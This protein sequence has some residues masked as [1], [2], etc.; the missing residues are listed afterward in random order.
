[1][2]L[3]L[4]LVLCFT[5]FSVSA[6]WTSLITGT[7]NELRS[8]DAVDA[9]LVYAAGANV[10]IKSING[11][12]NWSTLPLLN[13]SNQPINSLVINDL[14]FFDAQT[15]IAVGAQASFTRVILRTIDGG[16]HW[17]TIVTANDLNSWTGGY[18]KVHFVSNTHG[19]AVGS[20]GV[21]SRTVNGGLNW[22]TVTIPNVTNLYDVQF[23]DNQIGMVCGE[24]DYSGNG[25]QQILAQSTNGG[26]TWSQ[27]IQSSG[28]TL[29]E[30][31]LL[32]PLTVFLSNDQGFVIRLNDGVNLQNST[33][34]S[35]VDAAVVHRFHF[36]SNTSG[37]A[38]CDYSIRKTNNT[39]LFWE[40]A[41]LPLSSGQQLRDFDFLADGVTGFAVGKA[42]KA[43][44]TTNGGEPLLPMAYFYPESY[45]Y[46]QLCADSVY[47]FVNSAPEAEY[48]SQ[49]YVDGLLY[50]TENDIDISFPATATTYSVRLRITGPNG[51]S[52]YTQTFETAPELDFVYGTLEWVYG[53][54]VCA[55]GYLNFQVKNPAPNI[56]YTAF[57]NDVPFQALYVNNSDPLLF[58]T[59][60]MTE[61]AVI[62]VEATNYGPCGSLVQADT[63]QAPV[64]IYPDKNSAVET[65]TPI[66]CRYTSATVTIHDSEV[67]AFYLFTGGFTGATP[68]EGNGGDLT[69]LTPI[70]DQTG[71]F[72]IIA[73]RGPCSWPLNQTVYIQV[74]A[75]FNQLDTYGNYGMVGVPVSVSNQ[76]QGLAS[77]LWDF[78]ANASPS[79]TTAFEPSVVF[80]SSG[81][82][83]YTYNFQ[84]QGA[85]TGTIA[86]DFEIYDQGAPLQ[87]L[88][89]AFNP[90]E[91]LQWSN[92]GES[93]QVL[94]TAIDTAGNLLT[95]GAAF[96]PVGWWQTMN[97][98]LQ[99]S[100]PSGNL[101]WQKKVDPTGPGQGAEYRSAYGTG[102]AVD[103]DNQIY[104]C[105]TFAADQARIFGQNFSPTL[106]LN[107]YYPQGF[108]MKLGPNGNVLW[109]IKIQ[110]LQ[111][112]EPCAPSS[113]LYSALDNRLYLLLRGSSWQAVLP[114]G[115][116]AGDFNPNTAAWMIAFSL[117]GQFVEAKPLGDIPLT[118]LLGVFHPQLIS[119]NV[120]TSTFTSPRLREGPNGALYVGGMVANLDSI[121]FGAQTAIA[122]GLSPDLQRRSHF[123]AVYDRNTADWSHAFITHSIGSYGSIN[124]FVAPAWRVDSSGNV[125]VGLGLVAP[126][127]SGPGLQPTF[128]V[129]GD[130]APETV[131]NRGYLAQFSPSGQLN[132]VARAS[133]MY[134]HELQENGKGGMFVQ[135]GFV[136]AAGFQLPSGQYLG[137]AGIGNKDVL[138]AEISGAGAGIG[139]RAIGGGAYDQP[140]AMARDRSSGN[141]YSVFVPNLNQSLQNITPTPF[142]LQVYSSND[143]CPLVGIRE[144]AE[145]QI[146][147]QFSPNPV[148]NGT[149]WSLRCYLPSSGAAQVRLVD[150]LG[151]Q[152]W[153]SDLGQLPAGEN[154]LLLQ[155]VA[156]ALP[157]GVYLLT[158]ETAAGQGQV[159][160]VIMD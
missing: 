98:F 34:V 68:I 76:S 84:S 119:F 141:I 64:I 140:V 151:R 29:R 100:K 94:A 130:E 15:G 147:L 24:N 114:D 121:H 31:Y 118:A 133:N 158:L 92:F 138:L 154:K 32:D 112:N 83:P 129:I 19:W 30:L 59:P 28:A 110:S 7:N 45:T 81:S 66:V 86:D 69:F 10:L 117:D 16:A 155:P 17:S 125:W 72:Q 74:D 157:A 128:C 33:N 55:G 8:V 50:S 122:T 58:T 60:A 79:S 108:L 123:V 134:F 40:Q 116:L 70:L 82:M 106:P 52:D 97:L 5:L 104:L 22:T 99:K 14:H 57:I 23:I 150:L 101:L 102:L 127:T 49:W 156:A 160:V 145:E 115:N 48:T 38:L 85:C 36:T 11:G 148:A 103:P 109:S 73:S 53:P 132:W 18:S 46:F 47:H 62:R 25:S 67:G 107:K 152:V 88:D 75:F 144:I 120:A 56:T 96:Q 41:I 89:C 43:F 2:K 42:G 54:P 142:A 80:S 95:T 87:G 111:E 77:V 131:P 65:S 126:E 93:P 13:L 90:L 91:G 78:G 159:R 113:L 61:N 153:H 4:T 44:R 136:R 105:G 51:F 1:M 35:M 26:Q 137:T 149:A 37:Y 146:A 71:E 3:L 135:A 143:L 6:Q 20:S 27:W 12:L 21:V 139:F 124:D 9:D 39:G 63:L